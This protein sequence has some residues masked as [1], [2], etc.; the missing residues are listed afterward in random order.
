MYE[1][2]IDILSPEGKELSYSLNCSETELQGLLR[3]YD[4]TE[5]SYKKLQEA[6]LSQS[7]ESCLCPYCMKLRFLRTLTKEVY[8]CSD[9]HKKYFVAI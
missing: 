4:D 2:K 9:C 3:T 8:E 6:H 5:I 1:V 7:K